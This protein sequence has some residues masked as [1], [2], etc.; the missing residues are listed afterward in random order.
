ML[1]PQT[2][3][4]ISIDESYRN[5]SGGRADYRFYKNKDGNKRYFTE[6]QVNELPMP[7]EKGLL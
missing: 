7:G 5:S 6:I 3:R 2:T 4:H 1:Q